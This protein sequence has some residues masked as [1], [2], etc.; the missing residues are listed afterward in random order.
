MLATAALVCCGVANAAE[1]GRVE[2]R[3]SRPADAD[4]DHSR[5]EVIQKIGETRAGAEKL[6][7]LHEAERQRIAQEYERRK[8][9]YQQGL[10]ARNDVL[11]AEYA[12]KTNAG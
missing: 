6:L 3:R 1:L 8:E 10:I 5:S 9:L 4:L 2:M 11:T 7:A 12:L